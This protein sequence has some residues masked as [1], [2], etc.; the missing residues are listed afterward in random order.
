[1]SIIKTIFYFA[2]IS[3]MAFITKFF[4]SYEFFVLTII[5]IVLPIISEGLFFILYK[6]IDGTILSNKVE[7]VKNGKN[8]IILSF[9]CPC[10]TGR[11]VC[12][13][14]GKSKF[15]NDY[16]AQYNFYMLPFIKRK[17]TIPIDF[18]MVGAYRFKIEGLKVED[19]LGLVTENI[20]VNKTVTITVMPALNET[21]G[22]KSGNAE[23]DI[24]WAIHSYKS[25]SGDFAGIR[26]YIAGDRLNTIHWKATAARDEI[27]VREFEKVASDERI[28]L[29]DF[30]REYFDYSF[31]RLYSI[32]KAIIKECNSFYL[33][34]LTSGSEDLSVEYIDSN[35]KFDNIIKDMY[36]MYPLKGKNDTL[37]K[38]KR[39]F[40]SSNVLFISE[41]TELI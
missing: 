32:G 5:M 34:W 21:E 33:I 15:Y 27:L 3:A 8:N 2:I 38:F 12:N 7:I 40:G 20:N 4:H 14:S 25:A 29:F 9:K 22:M 18:K 31:D 13:L 19:P 11:A 30:N 1:M 28:I 10:F 35:N 23:A 39:Q 16:K 37:I 41:N 26:E 6:K 24:N 17:I 36:N